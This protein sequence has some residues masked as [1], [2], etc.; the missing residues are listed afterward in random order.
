[1]RASGARPARPLPRPRRTDAAARRGRSAGQEAAVAP[2]RS[3]LY[4]R[5]RAARTPD[6]D[7]ARKVH[8]P[9]AVYPSDGDAVAFA[10]GTPS[11]ALAVEALPS[12][13]AATSGGLPAS[14]RPGWHYRAPT[15]CAHT[16]EP[17]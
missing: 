9:P 6:P 15:R 14:R 10:V 13:V 12:T 16:R 4:D 11:K 8:P 17:A 5:R 1:M 2:A 7:D 3:A